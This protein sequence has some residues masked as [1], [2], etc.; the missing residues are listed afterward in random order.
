MPRMMS[1]WLAAGGA[2]LAGAT[3]TYLATRAQ[4]SAS[5]AP[6]AAKA[7]RSWSR[8]RS[9]VSRPEHERTSSTGFGDNRENNA[10]FDEYRD[11]ALKTLAEDEREFQDYLERLRHAKDRAEFDKFM[12]DRKARPAAPQSPEPESGLGAAR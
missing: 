10:A 9:L 12:A 8:V 7:A 4:T 11:A 5:T 6:I 3:F 1:M 2:A